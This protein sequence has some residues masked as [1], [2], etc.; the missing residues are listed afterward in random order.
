MAL[1]LLESATGPRTTMQSPIRWDEVDDA[2]PRDFTIFTMPARFA[3][4]GDL[5]AD[6]D[7]QVFDIAPLLAG[8]P[9]NI[10]KITADF[11]ANTYTVVSTD[12]AAKDTTYTGTWAATDSADTHRNDGMALAASS[13]PMPIVLMPMCRRFA[14]TATTRHLSSSP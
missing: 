5:H 10:T 7:D 4:L 11:Q 12:N 8:A 1:Q 13:S 14:S 3:E 6:I 9:F 2:D